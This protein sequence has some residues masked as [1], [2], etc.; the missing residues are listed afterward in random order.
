LRGSL[1]GSDPN[2]EGGRVL[3]Y[4]GWPLYTYVGDITA[5][6][7]KGEGLGTDGG[8]W[9]VITSSGKPITRTQ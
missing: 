3:T 6:A 7:A 4:A 1:L 9:F 2:P 8:L 5:D